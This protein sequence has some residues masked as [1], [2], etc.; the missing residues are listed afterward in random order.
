[1]Q[2][3]ENNLKCL[4]SERDHWRLATDLA[5]KE[6]EKMASENNQLGLANMELTDMVKE[7]TWVCTV[8]AG[9]LVEYIL[10]L[11]NESFEG[12]QHVQL[13]TFCRQSRQVVEHFMEREGGKQKQVQVQDEVRLVSAVLGSLISFSCGT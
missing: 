3:V 10:S 5:R 9:E 6:G 1:M 13:V 2:Q 4:T 7:Q 11:S 12:L 8:L